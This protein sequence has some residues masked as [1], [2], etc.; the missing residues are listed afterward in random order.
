MRLTRSLELDVPIA[1]VFDFFGDATNL[2]RITPLELSFRIVTPTPIAMA[3]GTLIDY[4]LKLHG[5]P[6]RWRTLISRWEP[7]FS[8]VDEQVAG[9][10]T[11][12]I[13]T[14]TFT[15][16]APA[17]TLIEDEVRYR[18]PLDPLSRIMLPVV[19]WQL[20]KIFDYRQVR[21]AQLLMPSATDVAARQS[22][23]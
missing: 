8:F 6:L 22:S 11:Q 20:A 17:R 15:E 19:R 10:Y 9:P 23:R 1:R 14:H 2:E 16:L 7:P 3:P 12:W 4:R 21:V 5:L 18:L 13:H